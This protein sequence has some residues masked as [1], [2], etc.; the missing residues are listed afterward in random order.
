MRVSAVLLVALCGL[1][2]CAHSPRDEAVQRPKDTFIAEIGLVNHTDRYIYTTSVDGRWGGHAHRTSAG[3]ASMCCVTL[4]ATW[5]PGLTVRVGWD[6]P[7]ET[8]HIPKSKIV[9]VEKYDEPGD[10]YVHF[11]PDDE[12]RVVVTRWIG[13]S[14]NH[15]IAPPPGTMMPRY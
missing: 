11:F 12:I 15:P 7:E 5:R 3:I 1:G 8:T 14:P 6:M 10:V 13:A 2:G 4:P 9:E